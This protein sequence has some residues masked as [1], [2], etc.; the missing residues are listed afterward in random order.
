M[1]SEICIRDRVADACAAAP[2]AAPALAARREQA[3]GS[4]RRARVPLR[5]LLVASNANVGGVGTALAMATAMGWPRLLA[6]AAAARTPPMAALA[7]AYSGWMHLM[8]ALALGV[9]C[10]MIEMVALAFV[11]SCGMIEMVAL[12]LAWSC[13]MIE[14]VS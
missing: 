3:G 7:L 9:S 13:G 6:P 8:A 10:W 4:N 2:A 1:G 14:N 5:T 11:C 12:A